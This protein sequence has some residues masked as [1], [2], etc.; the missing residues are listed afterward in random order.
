MSILI[1]PRLVALL[2]LGALALAA[3]G[4]SPE[5]E[6]WW[7]SQGAAGKAAGKGG[8]AGG[9]GVGGTSVGQGG[10]GAQGAQET[11]DGLDNNANGEVDEGCTCSPGKT[12]ACYTGPAE[13]RHVGECK[14]GSQTCEKS[15]EFG[16]WGACLGSVVP[17]QEIA[18]GKD[19]D[20]NGTPDDVCGGDG[21]HGPEV[22]GNGVDDDCDG[23]IDCKDSDCPGGCK[24]TKCSDGQDDDEDGQV[25][26]VDPDCQGTADCKESNCADGVD[27]DS[28]GLVDCKD[29]DC[30]GCKEDCGDGVDNDGDGMVDC[31]DADCASATNCQQNCGPNGECCNGLDDNGDGR[32]DEG[33]VCR[34]VGEPC[35]PGAYQSCD[36][37]CGVHRKC[38]PDGTWGPCFVDGNGSCAIA[39]VTSQSQCGGGYC[40]Y[41]ECVY[42][43]LGSSQCVHHSDCPKPM[44]CDLGQCL[45]DPYNPCP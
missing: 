45:F 37:Y 36:C 23:L 39:A 1:H 3:C 9:S 41:G 4:S 16:I 20:C 15:A 43:P 12:Q 44:V 25:D 31:Q 34:N 35:P 42:F 38:K 22:C 14:D 6:P 28:D 33:D 27:N 40:D 21:P 2:G 5:D 8:N 13:T 26:C 32:I 10:S 17:S 7:Y 29:P 24:E 11:C 18:D 30:P 19:N